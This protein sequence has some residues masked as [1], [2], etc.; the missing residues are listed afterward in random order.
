MPITIVVP[1]TEL[2]NEIDGSFTTIK[3]QTL[4]L[5]HSL[6]SISKWESIWKKPFL[7]NTPKNRI[8]SISYIECMTI[9]KNV[10]SQC[11]LALTDEQLSMVNKYIDDPMTA[12]TFSNNTKNGSRASN[13]SVTSELIYY[14]MISFN[15]PKEMEKWHL[16]RLLTLI[17]I[18]NI[19]NSPK[20]NM[21]KT[22]IAAQNR[23]L[24]A[25]RRKKY[26]TKG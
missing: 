7:S 25:A 8:E 20:S 2:Y 18:C 17:K 15:I 3:E 24:N 9:N 5:E 14:W 26:G 6:I 10:N 23:A 13:R 12:T 4:V 1:S 21:S 16:S 22:E 19:E 11:Y